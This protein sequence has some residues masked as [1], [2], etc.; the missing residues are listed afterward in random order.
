MQLWRSGHSGPVGICGIGPPTGSSTIT[1]ALTTFVKAADKA[2]DGWFEMQRQIDAHQLKVDLMAIDPKQVD[3]VFKREHW[4]VLG[5]KTIKYS[6]EDWNDVATAMPVALNK[7]SGPAIAAHVFRP[8]LAISA[9]IPV[10]PGIANGP[11]QHYVLLLSFDDRLAKLYIDQKCQGCCELN[12]LG[13]ADQILNNILVAAK[14]PLKP[15]SAP[16]AN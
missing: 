14:Q 5:K 16:S 2:N 12:N 10:F 15:K 7:G 1:D 3:D 8:R 11:W 4:N 9:R 13:G 6:D